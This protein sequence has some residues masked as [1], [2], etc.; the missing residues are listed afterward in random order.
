MVRGE[1]G[2]MGSFAL[3]LGIFFFFWSGRKSDLS[4]FILSMRT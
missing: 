4:Y 2:F 1:G 3:G